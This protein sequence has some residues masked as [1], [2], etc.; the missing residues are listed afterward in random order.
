[1]GFAGKRVFIS[2]GSEGIGRSTA[3]KLAEQGAHVCVVARRQNA[4]DETVEAMRKAVG[5]DSGR[6]LTAIAMDVTDPA[7]VEEGA[8]RALEAL[9]GLDLLICNQGFAH[10]GKV[11]ELPIEDFRRHL[12]VN[13]L[14]HA[15]VCR[16]FAPH[17]LKQG[18]GTIILVSSAFGYFGTYGWTAYCA[19]KWAIVGFAEALRQEMGLHGVNVKVFYPGTT[20]TPGL[21]REN[22]DKSKAVWEFEHA[23]AFN[24]TRKPDDVAGRLLAIV[25][26]RRFENPCGWDGWLSFMASRHAPWLVR[27]LN[28]SDMRKALA[29]HGE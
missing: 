28:D 15:Y 26:G 24:V 19:S 4:L 13:Y 9:G 23:N 29:K 14:G 7:A 3:V 1:M 12:D 6:V 20:E 25:D 11:H 17:F 16:A 2:G 27:M 18:S 8:R 22:S 21:D 5:G 10:T